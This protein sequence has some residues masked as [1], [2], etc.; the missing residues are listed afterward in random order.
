MSDYK[1]EV[2]MIAEELAESLYHDEFYSLPDHLRDEVYNDAMK[3]YA[4]RKAAYIDRLRDE[5]KYR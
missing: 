5:A 4:E 1:Y 3:E 2:Q